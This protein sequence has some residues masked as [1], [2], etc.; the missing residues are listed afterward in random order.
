MSSPF[1]EAVRGTIPSACKC[2]VCTTRIRM[3]GNPGD[4][5][6]KAKCPGCGEVLLIGIKVRYTAKIYDPEKHG[7]ASSV[8]CR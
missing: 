1:F 2:P 3:V 4:W 5:Q 6:A 7:V 8:Q